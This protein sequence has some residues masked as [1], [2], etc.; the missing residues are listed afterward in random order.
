MTDILQLQLAKL[1][2]TMWDILW[3][4]ICVISGFCH[5]INEILTF[6]GFH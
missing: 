1:P 5:G 3:I 2:Q 4:G 6:V